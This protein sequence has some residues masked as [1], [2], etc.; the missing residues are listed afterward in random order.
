ENV[1]IHER[2][3]AGSLAGVT[4]LTTV[5]K[6]RMVLRTT[7]QYSGMMDC[8]KKI[9]KEEGAKAFYRGCF[10][11]M[12]SVVPAVGLDLALYEVN[13][14]FTWML[15]PLGCGIVSSSTVLKT[16]MVLR[17]T[18]QYSGMMD[19]AKKILKEEGAKAFYRGLPHSEKVLY[20]NT[21]LSA[22]RLHVLPVCVCGFPPGELVRLH[23]CWVRM[24]ERVVVFL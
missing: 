1:K 10:T 8:A 12:L 20:S 14:P 17:T 4:A 7:A 2:F 22:L 15:L 21:G 19:C 11:S 23:C 9:L 16:R 6:T 13:R 18:A 24:R 5:L 3:V